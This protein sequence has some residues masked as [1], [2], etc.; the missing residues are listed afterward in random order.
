M[1]RIFIAVDIPESIR[2][3]IAWLETPGTDLQEAVTTASS[4]ASV[5]LLSRQSSMSVYQN[6]TFS[7]LCTRKRSKA[8]MLRP[9]TFQS[10]RLVLPHQTA[11]VPAARTAVA[12]H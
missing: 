10:G 1:P 7:E 12:D 5:L 2:R 3:K 11:K 9:G 8:R 6:S 4:V